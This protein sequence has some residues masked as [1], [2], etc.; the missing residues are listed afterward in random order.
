MLP[1][2]DRINIHAYKLHWARDYPWVSS[3]FSGEVVQASAIPAV[4]FH[5]LKSLGKKCCCAGFVYNHTLRLYL[6]SGWA[7][8]SKAKRIRQTGV[9]RKSLDKSVKQET[10]FDRVDRMELCL[11]HLSPSQFPEYKEENRRDPTQQR[12]WSFHNVVSLLLASWLITLVIWRESVF[13]GG[14]WILL[15]LV[16]PSMFKL[17][18]DT[19]TRFHNITSCFSVVS[20]SSLIVSTLTQPSKQANKTKNKTKLKEQSTHQKKHETL[21]APKDIKSVCTFLSLWFSKNAIEENSMLSY[22]E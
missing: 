6:I 22:V 12:P 18:H 10:R 1:T 14:A 4:E 13:P 5:T 11:C 20:F 9:H 7:E 3:F 16:N 19:I 2:T 21:Q 17:V 15:R 8:K